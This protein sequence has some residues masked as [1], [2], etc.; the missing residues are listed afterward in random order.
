MTGARSHKRHTEAGEHQRVLRLTRKVSATLGND[1]F[2]SLVK[3]MA[4]ALDADCVYIG[5]LIRG[6][7][8]RIDALAV[9]L[10]GKLAEN[11]EQDLPGSASAQVLAEGNLVCPVDVTELFPLDR[12]LERL[13]AQAFVGYRLIDSAGQPLGVLAAIYSKRLADVEVAKSVVEA[14]TPRA[15][16]EL[17]RKCDHDALRR[18]NERHRA[19]VASS[20]D[21]MWRIEFEKPIPVHLDEEEQIERI[22]RYGYMA[23]CNEALARLVNAPS[24]EEL[25]G[26]RFAAIVPP[27]DERW[28]EE[29]RAAIRSGYRTTVVETTPLDPLGRRMYRLR[30]QFGIVEN[31]ELLRL[32]GTM[33]DIT[34]LKRAELAL[35][36]SERRFRDMLE[37][38]QLPAVMV[39]P[40]GQV[41]CPPAAWPLVE[42]RAH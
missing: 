24:V 25:I 19:F 13:E 14:F 15:A 18:A 4:V 1:F 40:A 11:F 16:A 17:E 28:V 27:T 38:L 6:A 23:E 41:L 9:C 12:S 5:E 31:G 34:G 22:Y 8:D 42:T 10:D 37:R 35:E 29:L 26:A 20:M 2:E 7:V 21:A 30:S 36:A 3:H 32:W 39:D 33:R